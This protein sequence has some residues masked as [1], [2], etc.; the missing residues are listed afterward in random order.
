MC[1]LLQEKR[2]RITIPDVDEDRWETA[3]TPEAAS[4]PPSRGCPVFVMLPLDTVWVVERDGKQVSILKKEKALEIALHTLRQVC[5]SAARLL[6]ATAAARHTC[7]DTASGR[8]PVV[9]CG[10]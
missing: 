5:S 10:C 8:R 2:T 4:T 1:R 6:T 3:S 9:V 7:K